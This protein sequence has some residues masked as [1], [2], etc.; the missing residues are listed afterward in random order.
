MV[1]E[2]TIFPFAMAS[3]GFNGGIMSVTRVDKRGSNMP[4]TSL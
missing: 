3:N 2:M 1:D 4:S